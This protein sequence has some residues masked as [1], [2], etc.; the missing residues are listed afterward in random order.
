MN[1]NQAQPRLY[2]NQSRQ[3]GY[4]ILF[5]AVFL[6]ILGIAASQ[7]FSRSSESTLMSGAV[8]DQDKALLLAESALEHLRI[9]FA[10]KR[11]DSDPT[12]R[13]ADCIDIN[14]N[15]Q[16]ACE[17]ALLQKHMDS[18]DG[19]LFNYMYYVSNSSGLDVNQPSVLQKLADGEATNVSESTLSSQKITNSTQRLRISDLFSN[20]FKP[21]LYTLNDNGRVIPSTASDWHSES[22]ENK[23]AVWVEVTQNPYDSQS[24]DL[25]V[26]SAAQVAKA[27]RYL[28]RYV[29]SYNSTA[30]LGFVSALSEA[31]NINR[32]KP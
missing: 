5:A 12:I 16:D 29:G 19:Y 17:A 20:T 2:P 23:A 15:T 22:N 9:R 1:I 7:L 6:L 28:Q 11:L 32:A 14:G 13:T 4:I 21:I 31:S 26:Q 10:T 30:M 8:R 18:P 24:V 27:K 3:S 25:F